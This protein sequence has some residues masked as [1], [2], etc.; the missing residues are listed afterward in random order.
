MFRFLTIVC[1]LFTTGVLT[2]LYAQNDYYFPPNNSNEWETVSFEELG[3]CSDHVDELLELLEARNTKGFLLLY[4]GRLVM[5][6]YF[7]D[8]TQDSLW[9]WN[10]AGK[11][12]TAFS[13]GMAQQSGLIDIHQ[14]TSTYLGEGWTSLDPA[15]EALITPWHQLTM[16]TGLDDGL[17]PHCTDP[18]C[19]QYLADA[20]T[21]WAYHNGPYTNLTYVIEEA[22]GNGINNFVLS[23]FGLP[24]GMTGFYF[25]FDYNRVFISKPRDMAR[26]GLMML[27][28]GTWNGTTILDD[29]EY[30]EAMLTPSQTLNESY[31]YL[32]WLNEGNSYMVPGLQTSFPGPFLSE[33]PADMKAALG[34]DAQLLNVVPSND[35][36]L[37]RMGLDPE[38]GLVPFTFNNDIWEL[39]N[40]IICDDNAVGDDHTPEALNVAPVPSR[41]MLQVTGLRPD[42]C[43]Q[44]FNLSGQCVLETCERRFSVSGLEAGMYI[45]FGDG[46]STK[47]I[48]E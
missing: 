24:I 45:L 39:L 3:W 26:F 9:V 2:T 6:N 4:K 46:Q 35:L 44:L 12:V 40:L 7:G 47:V 37:V 14:P 23:Q 30:V 1:L 29:P 13:I 25:P 36:V 19:L 28:N 34:K 18:E 22:T 31:G 8:F 16:T 21:R 20:G 33:A 38:T 5:E 27:A 15:Q 32:W 11:T 42:A 43:L 41:D 48:V 10:S 17:D